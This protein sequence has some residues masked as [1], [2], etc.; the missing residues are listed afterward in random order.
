MDTAV[1]WTQAVMTVGLAVCRLVQAPLGLVTAACVVA[2]GIA[3]AL[4]YARPRTNGLWMQT[5]GLASLGV[6][7]LAANPGETTTL[8]YMLLSGAGLGIIAGWCVRA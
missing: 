6:G 7:W 2:A 3:I 8:L 1:L 4:L 5:L